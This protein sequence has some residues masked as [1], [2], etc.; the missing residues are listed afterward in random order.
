MNIDNEVI[1]KIETKEIDTFFD[2]LT[3]IL[4]KISGNTLD[5][6]QNFNKCFSKV[7]ICRYLSMSTRLLCYAE[8]LNKMQ[9]VLTNKQFYHLAYNIIP[10]QQSA[11][12]RYIKKPAKKEK[13]IKNDTSFTNISIFDI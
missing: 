11:F 3:D 10:K 5:K 1:L 6:C 4:L 12:I 9:M 7:M 2:C 8:Y 13:E